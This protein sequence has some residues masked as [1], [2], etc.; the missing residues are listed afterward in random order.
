LNCEKFGEI[1]ERASGGDHY[2]GGETNCDG[3]NFNSAEQL[4]QKSSHTRGGAKKKKKAKK[5][6]ISP[7]DYYCQCFDEKD[8]TSKT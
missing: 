4:C 7:T 5:P 1:P 8:S 3:K 2:G 6:L